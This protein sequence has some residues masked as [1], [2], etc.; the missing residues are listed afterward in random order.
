MA[1][2]PAPAMHALPCNALPCNALH[3]DVLRCQHAP[4]CSQGNTEVSN[5]AIAA[6]ASPHTPR[7][8]SQETGHRYVP[9]AR[10][11]RP[12]QRR[13]SGAAALSATLHRQPPGAGRQPGHGR[14]TTPAPR[15]RG[16]RTLCAAP[17]GAVGLRCRGRR[18]R[19]RGAR[20]R[21]LRQRRQDTGTAPVTHHGLRAAPV[22]QRRPVATTGRHG[23][24]FPGHQPDHPAPTPAR[25]SHELPVPPRPRA[26]VSLRSA[27]AAALATGQVPGGR[28]RLSRDQ[29]LLPRFSALD[30]RELQ[31]VQAAPGTTRPRPA[32]GG[33]TA[34]ALPPGAAAGNAA[35][36]PAAALHPARRRL[37]RRDGAG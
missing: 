21:G 18:R 33:E 6:H 12:G 23:R 27:A 13:Q 37:S 17:G 8:T 32:A 34:G 2:T 22:A 14:D 36:S 9:L 16:A 1:G 5:A 30:R 31:R 15:T 24:R 11:V 28:A 4:Q 35:A 20:G 19:F 29:Q 10:H 7:H 3:C 26:P 25:R